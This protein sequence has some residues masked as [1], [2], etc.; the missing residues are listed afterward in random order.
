M[1]AA[2]HTV[3]LASPLNRRGGD[4]GA[5]E[6]E[7]PEERLGRSGRAEDLEWRLRRWEGALPEKQHRP[8]RQCSVPE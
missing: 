2:R 5:G 6:G 4:E 8:A 7:E 1:N 3:H